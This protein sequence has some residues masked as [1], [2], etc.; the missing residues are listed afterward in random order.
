MPPLSVSMPL[1]S[2]IDP[3]CNL[4]KPDDYSPKLVDNKFKESIVLVVAASFTLSA[5]VTATPSDTFSATF[6]LIV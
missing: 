5:T 6:L 3:L 2:S 4:S 1:T